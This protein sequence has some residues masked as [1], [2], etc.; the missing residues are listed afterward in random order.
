MLVKTQSLSIF[1]GYYMTTQWT[2]VV[3]VNGSITWYKC[4]DNAFS[5]VISAGINEPY[6]AIP[7][8]TRGITK[9]KLSDIKTW[10][11]TQ[12]FAYGRDVTW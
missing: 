3:G 8:K 6:L 2:K 9:I 12:F 4:R 10:N 5:I 1:K 11:N 7:E